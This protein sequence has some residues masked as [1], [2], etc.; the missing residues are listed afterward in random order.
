MTTRPRRVGGWRAERQAA[1]GSCGWTGE[2][3]TERL[4]WIHGGAVNTRE[5]KQHGIGSSEKSLKMSDSSS[6]VEFSLVTHA[7]V[8][9]YLLS[10]MHMHV[11]LH[12]FLCFWLPPSLFVFV[13][14]FVFSCLPRS[15]SCVVTRN[16]RYPL[17]PLV[18][19]RPA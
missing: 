8:S 9:P 10:G 17:E 7:S 6:T 3:R 1:E 11:V 14:L 12:T 5:T 15:Y 13:R 2:R 18:D 16:V 4:A 19:H